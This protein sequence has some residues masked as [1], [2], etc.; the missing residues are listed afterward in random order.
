MRSYE[1]LFFFLLTGAQQ[2]AC[3]RLGC[4]RRRQALAAGGSRGQEGGE[5]EAR[6]LADGAEDWRRRVGGD[7][8]RVFDEADG[9]T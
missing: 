2:A 5:V 4:Y 6:A 1:L 3:C 8:E 7:G 9:G